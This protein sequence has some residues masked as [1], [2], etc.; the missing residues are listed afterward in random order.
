MESD[1]KR[2]SK[3]PKAVTFA[4]DAMGMGVDR[5]ETPES[6]GRG[7]QREL[8]ASSGRDEKDEMHGLAFKVVVKAIPSTAWM[9]CACQGASSEFG[10]ADG[11][12]VLCA[13]A[14]NI[15]RAAAARNETHALCYVMRT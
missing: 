6:R 10:L 12:N 11:G 2:R 14:M 15:R 4:D 1:E 3:R 7:G 9:E 8:V 13:S 5:T